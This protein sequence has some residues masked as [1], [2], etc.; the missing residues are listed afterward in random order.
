MSTAPHRPSRSRWQRWRNKRVYRG[1]TPSVPNETAEYNGA[2]PDMFSEST[3]RVPWSEEL[4]TGTGRTASPTFVPELIRGNVTNRERLDHLEQVA[5]QDPLARYIVT[6]LSINTFDDWF[7]IVDK[8]GKEHK[9]N[10]KIQK[11]LRSLDA[12][13]VYTRCEITARKF[14]WCWQFVGKEKLDEGVSDLPIRRISN[15]DYF[16]PKELKVSKTD[17]FGR[18]QKLR[19]RVTLE[20]IDP[21]T[22]QKMK[23]DQEYDADQF[24]LWCPDPIGRSYKGHPALVGAWDSLAELRIAFDS[25]TWYIKKVG[26]GAWVVELKKHVDDE[27]AAAIQTMFQKLNTRTV[28]LVNQDKTA[29]IE[30]KGA[31]ISTASFA[32]IFRGLL[33]RVAAS[34]QVPTAILIGSQAGQITGSDVNLKSLYQ[35]LNGIQTSAERP[36][37]RDIRGHGF[38]DSDMFFDWGVK[39]VPDSEQKARTEYLHA[40]M[41]TLKGA[42]MTTNEIRAIEGLAPLPDGDELM[43]TMKIQPLGAEP[44]SDEGSTE[45]DRNLAEEN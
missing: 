38:D 8:D 11:I 4:G 5:D 13:F 7:T 6:G 43:S 23:I 28:A 1:D 16:S 27:E 25:V 44:S 10:E 34:T 30:F 9:D 18:P 39:F 29:N 31:Q 12:Q 37:R 3:A 15:Y 20:T 26:M 21:D 41:L 22:G 40:E 33:E 14:G 19:H 17:K 42:W 36:I 35:V 2:Y 32:E 45:Q 24:I